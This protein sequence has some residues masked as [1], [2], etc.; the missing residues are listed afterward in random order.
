MKGS[1]PAGLWLQSLGR[2]ARF[3]QWLYRRMRLRLSDAWIFWLV[4]AAVLIL[5][6][7][8]GFFVGYR[9]A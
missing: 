1:R 7:G 8:L 5:V 9:S 3:R 6:F 2:E 4:V